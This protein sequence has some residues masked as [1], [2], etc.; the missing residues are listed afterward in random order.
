[1][2]YIGNTL[3]PG[4][5]NYGRSGAVQPISALPAQ[6]AA[7]NGTITFTFPHVA[8]GQVWT[9]TINVGGAPD[10]ATFTALTGASTFGQFKG[11][12]SWGPIQLGGGDQLIVNGTGLVPGTLY[13][14]SFQGAAVTGADP[15]IIY[16]SAYADTVTTSTEQLALGEIKYN[17]G[18]GAGTP[19]TIV[20]APAYRSVWVW[21]YIYNDGLPFNG[22]ILSNITVTGNVTGEN[23]Y[24][25]FPPYNNSGVGVG[26]TNYQFIRIPV[27]NGID[28]QLSVTYNLTTSTSP[29]GSASITVEWGA[30]LATLDLGVYQ[31]GTWNVGITGTPTISGTVA[32][33]SVAGTVTV[34]NAAGNAIEV[35]EVGGLS[36]A[37]INLTSTTTT[38]LLAAPA[39]GKAY[40]IH[41]ICIFGNTASQTVRFALGSVPFATLIIGQAPQ[42][43]TMNGLT[44]TGAVTVTS[45]AATSIFAYVTYDL[46]TTPTIS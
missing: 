5:E 44:T 45:S 23:Y 28:T 16:P 15:G 10:S 43:M 19:I 42:A 13:Q 17:T 12:N 24:Y 37:S 38:N 33:S 8:L 7:S 20:L 11:S 22:A 30:D 39:T 4:G 31:E 25:T 35:Y 34:D 26:G 9:G 27:T 14:C 1:M 36:N 2:S 40:R 3:G 18:G 29:P 46:I 41:S 21:W 6:T 32:V